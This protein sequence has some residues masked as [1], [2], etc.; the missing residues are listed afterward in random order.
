ML[1]QR[2]FALAAA[3]ALATAV[4]LAAQSNSKE[5]MALPPAR[6]VEILKNP[7]ATEFEKA[8]ACQRLAVVGTRD[9]IAALVALLPDERLNLYARFAL[10]GI[11][12]PAVN[13]AL[14]KAATTLQGRQQVGV[15]DSI[16]QRKDAQA[17]ELLQGLLAAADRSVAS[18]A[19]GA[20]GRIGT[21]EAAAVLKQALTAGLAVQNYV[22]D[23]C[24]ACA[25]G[26]IAAGT[27]NDALALYEAVAKAGV[28]GHLRVAAFHGQMRVMGAGGTELLLAQLRAPDAAMFRAGLA[29]ARTV[30]GPQVTAALAAELPKLPEERQALLLL[31]L[32]SRK[33][34]EVLPHAMAA[35]NSASPAVR[36][37]AIEVLSRAGDAAAIPVLLDA[38]LGEGSAATAAKEGLKSLAGAAADEAIVG[39]LAGAD[40]KAK[41]VLLEIAGARGAVAATPA[42]IKALSETD[43]SARLAAI[44]ALGQLADAKEMELLI[45]RALGGGEPAE[46]QAA[47]AALR[48]A[49]QRMADREACSARLAARL[50][51]AS[52]EDQ[53]YL[54]EL[55]A[56]LA[57][58]KALQAVANAARSSEPAIKDAATRVLGEWPNALAAPTL[59]DIARNDPEVKYQIR[60]LRGY[61]RIARQLL[62][63]DDERLAMFRTAME[64]AKRNDE[65]QLALDILTRVPS[66][67]TLRLAVSYLGD[68]ALRAAAADAAVNIAG[69]L[70]TTQPKAV[71]EAMRKVIESRAAGKTGSRAKELLERAQ[72]TRTGAGA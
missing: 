29:A 9:A 27:K 34:R 24:L 38:A 3:L 41:V 1:A 60:A 13:D 22:A 51:G 5:I 31:A 54:L 40:A 7:A 70:V 59:L 71:A 61:I 39:R 36:D 33:G 49:A 42:A 28:P 6:L 55:L 57:D 44:A 53:V 47:Q 64:T 63:A 56:T 11:P 32:G 23:A 12:D 4:P 10:E 16:G 48:T 65:R 58:A 50:G 46:K 21:A 8:K 37:A 35:A 17:V 20:L 62:L 19:A 66:V 26:L 45:A 30:P 2:H 14:R 72:P 43:A 15:I 25:E 67:D 18:A 52:A 68:K 69:K